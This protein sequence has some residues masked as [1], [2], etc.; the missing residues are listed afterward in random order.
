MKEL[1]LK[2]K[3]STGY[4]CFDSSGIHGRINQR[5]KRSFARQ[6]NFLCI[7]KAH[8]RRMEEIF[9]SLYPEYR[10][11]LAKVLVERRPKSLRQRRIA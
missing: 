5:F 11:E 4:K 9:D 1:K 3:L 8:A 7:T 10:G 2:R 6:N